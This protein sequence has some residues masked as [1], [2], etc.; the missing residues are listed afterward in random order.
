MSYD[1]Q[2]QLTLLY[3]PMAFVEDSLP[4]LK[5]VLAENGRGSALQTDLRMQE[6]WIKPHEWLPYGQTPNLDIYCQQVYRLKLAVDQKRPELVN[7]RGVVFRQ[8]NHRAR[9][10]IVTG[11]KLPKLGWKVLIH[12]PYTLVDFMEVMRVSCP[13]MRWVLSLSLGAIENSSS[14]PVKSFVVQ[15]SPVVVAW[16]VGEW[17]TSFGVV[18]VILNISKL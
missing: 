13:S 6:E 7:R 1:V 17:G 4:G 14:C 16:K 3:H 5:L 2:L 12:P 11:Q 15:S 8:D 9:T 18:L 10:S